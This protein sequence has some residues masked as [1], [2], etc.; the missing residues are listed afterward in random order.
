MDIGRVSEQ[1]Q[2]HVHWGC[3]GRQAAFDRFDW[4]MTEGGR[5]L[6]DEGHH[7][8]RMKREPVTVVPGV[9][10]GRGLAGW[11]LCLRG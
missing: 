11:P 7:D 2:M 9:L 10:G 8:T 6:G 1:S 3:L 5:G 4:A